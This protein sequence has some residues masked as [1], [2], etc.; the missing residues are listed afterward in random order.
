MVESS[1]TH[2]KLESTPWREMQSGPLPASAPSPME[3]EVAED[4]NRMIERTESGL[5]LLILAALLLWIPVIEIGGLFVGAIAVILITL[6]AQAFGWRH[7]MLVW[8]S[9]LLF[10]LAQVAGLVLAGSFV[11][12]IRSIPSS[13]PAAADQILSAFD[14]LIRGVLVLVVIASISEAL[15][16]F[17]LSDLTGRVLLLGAVVVQSLVSVILLLVVFGPLIHQA[18]ADAFASGTFN[19][20]PIT[21]ASARINGLSAYSLLNS[22]PALMF[23]AAFYLTYRRVRQNVKRSLPQSWLTPQDPSPPSL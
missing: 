21:D 22:I 12:T 13:E 10:I 3:R 2:G 19:T 8:T 18:V 7:Q 9:V 4:R 17:D 5:A 20:G 15:I 16:A 6:G 14:G 1:D 11:S 23:A